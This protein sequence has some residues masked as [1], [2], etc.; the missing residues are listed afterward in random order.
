MQKKKL[1][2]ELNWQVLVEKD[3]SVRNQKNQPNP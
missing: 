2:N 1:I 3:A